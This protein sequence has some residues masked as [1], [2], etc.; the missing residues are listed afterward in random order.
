MSTYEAYDIA[1]DHYDQSRQAEGLEIVLGC[2][3]TLGGELDALSLLDAGCGTGNYSATLAPHL[4]KVT[5]LDMSAGMLAQARSKLGP[6]LT[7]GRAALHQGSITDMPFADGT[8]DAV[9]FNQV[10]H[11]L[12]RGIDPD[13][14]GHLA[15]VREAFRVLRPGG[16]LLINACS[17]IQLEQGFWYYRLLPEGLEAVLA[18]CAPASRLKEVIGQAG[19]V[20][21]ERIVPLESVLQGESYFDPRGPLDPAWRKGDSIWSL[22]PAERIEAAEQEIRALDAAGELEGYVARHDAPRQDIG[23]F[24]FFSATKT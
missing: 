5:G 18:R 6:E 9:I 3:A 8:F 14:G 21:R 20:L 12:E 11:H 15:A 16:M 13:Y 10:L 23:Q 17:H 4:G 19:L 24:S 2:L 1:A 7:A 22:V